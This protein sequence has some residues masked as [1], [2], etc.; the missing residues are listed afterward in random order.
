MTLAVLPLNGLIAA[1]MYT[2]SRCA[3]KAQGLRVRHARLGFLAFFLIY[4]L[5][6]SPASVGG[7][8]QEQ[9]HLR[10]RW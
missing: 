3:Y 7:Y 1:V 6:I 10:K 4:Q 9:L 5:V 8:T 2:H